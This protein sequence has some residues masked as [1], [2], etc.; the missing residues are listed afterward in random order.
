MISL[1]I[2]RDRFAALSRISKRENISFPRLLAGYGYNAILHRACFEDYC[3]FKLYAHS[4]LW[5]KNFLTWPRLLKLVPKFNKTAKESDFALIQ[6]KASFNAL[7]SAYIKRDWLFIPDHSEEDIR[8]FLQRNPKFLLKACTGTQGQGISLFTTDSLDPDSFLQEYVGK[9]FLLEAFIQQHPALAAPNPSSVNTI[10]IVTARLGADIM[11]VGAGLRCGGSHSFVDNL[12]NGG[13]AYPIN[14]EKGIVSGP[15]VDFRA[16]NTFLRH[17]SSNYVMPGLAIPYWN[18]LLQ[19]VREA[20]ILTPIGYVGWDVAITETGIEIIE[21][22]VKY[23]GTTVIQLDRPDAY[24]R[25]REF[26][27]NHH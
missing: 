18:T 20:S 6:D 14:L 25:L 19:T 10:R 24:K 21:A 8:A 27:K 2:I 15:G 11:L 3:T 16:E 13:A 5:K 12:H 4:D 1:E 23:P 22:N 9:P 7:F 26:Y 17:P